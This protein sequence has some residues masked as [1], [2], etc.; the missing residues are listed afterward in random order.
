MSLRIGT[1]HSIAP[2]AVGGPRRGHQ[3][4]RLRRVGWC[5]FAVFGLVARRLHVAHVCRNEQEWKEQRPRFQDTQMLLSVSWRAV[6]R[7]GPP[8]V[9]TQLWVGSSWG[10]WDWRLN[11]AQ[12]AASWSGS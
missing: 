11:R 12:W 4:P 10:G 5:L 8:C 1:G 6:L 2:L 9:G 3:G 7:T